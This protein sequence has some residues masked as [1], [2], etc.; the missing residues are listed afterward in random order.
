M[1]EAFFNDVDPRDDTDEP[2][3]APTE[4]QEPRGFRI[5]DEGQAR[6]AIE[7]ILV[8]RYRLALRERS[9]EAMKKD[10][11]QIEAWHTPLLEDYYRA[12]KLPH[13]T[14]TLKLDVGSLSTRTVP[15]GVRVDDEAA[16]LEWAEKSGFHEAITRQVV[17]KLD[18]IR[19]QRECEKLYGAELAAAFERVDARTPE[20][21]LALAEVEAKRALP[22]GVVVVPDRESFSVKPPKGA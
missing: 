9:L 10:L 17:R 4:E 11:K 16:C 1:S 8:A 15:G 12:Q 20:E 5:A 6:Y 22:P 3:D 18:V 21:A 2:V 14:K 13:G 7:S 19:V